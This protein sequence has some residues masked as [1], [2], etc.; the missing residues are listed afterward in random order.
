MKKLYDNNL[1]Q[2]K[3][4][5]LGAINSSTRTL[6]HSDIMFLSITVMD[7]FHIELVECLPYG[8]K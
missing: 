8:N 7:R 6:K 2:R 4:L 3:V 1:F 5:L